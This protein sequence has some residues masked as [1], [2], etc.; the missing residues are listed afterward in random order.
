MTIVHLGLPLV[1]KEL[2]MHFA[3]KACSR[4]LDLYV[5][6]DERVLEKQ[7]RNLTTFQMPFGVLRLV[8]LPIG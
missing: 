5:G 1:T 8:T 6:Y 7:S 2:A 4:I 3:R